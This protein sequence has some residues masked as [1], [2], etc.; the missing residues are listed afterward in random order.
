MRAKVFN[1]VKRRDSITVCI[2]FTYTT[3]W[4]GIWSHQFCLLYAKEVHSCHHFVHF[5]NKSIASCYLPN[6]SGVAIAEYTSTT[7]SYTLFACLFVCS[8]IRSVPGT[9]KLT[10]KHLV[11]NW[12]TKSWKKWS[13]WTKHAFRSIFPVKW[14]NGFEITTYM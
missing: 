9:K 1:R 10:T 6:S 7:S 11:S 8:C 5:T 2:V 13:R 3:R 12:W 14:R 4:I